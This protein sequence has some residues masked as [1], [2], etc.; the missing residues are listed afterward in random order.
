MTAVNRCAAIKT[1][2]TQLRKVL[3]L[4]NWQMKDSIEAESADM[5]NIMKMDHASQYD[6]IAVALDRMLNNRSTKKM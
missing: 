1:K 5:H 6:C 3:F 4:N 2:N